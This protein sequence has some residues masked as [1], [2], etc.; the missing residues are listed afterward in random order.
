MPGLTAPTNYEQVYKILAI[1]VLSCLS[2]YA[3]RASHL[4]H[5]GDNLHHL[6]HGG[7][8]VDGTK[9]ISYFKPHTSHGANYKWSAACAI[10][11]LSLLIFAQ[12]RFNSRPV[13]TSVRVCAHCTSNSSV[14]SDNHR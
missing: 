9:R 4:P 11:F 1:G 14:P 5:V 8:Y 2:I 13:S 7:N 3:L 6:P 10:G 12:T